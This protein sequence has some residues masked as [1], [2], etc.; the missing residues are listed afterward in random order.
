MT[1]A[2][3]DVE[4]AALDSFQEL[5]YACVFGPDIAPDGPHPERPSFAE[6]VLTERLRQALARIN[7]RIPSGALD[8]AVRKITS[9]D[10]PSLIQNN[11]RVHRML[12]DGVDV[13]YQAKDGRTVHDKAWLLDFEEPE[14]NDWLVANQF[15]VIEGHH[16]R[17]PD[18]VV[19]VNGL[20][21]AL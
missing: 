13:S 12:V 4:Q 15:T 3:S 10:S 9:T 20:P 21:L 16:N 18:V 7:R 2:E 17:R 19:F 1:F 6:T 11:R 5:D 14:N 8:D